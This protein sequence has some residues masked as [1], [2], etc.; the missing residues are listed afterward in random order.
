METFLFWAAVIFL[1]FVAL[2]AVFAV[3]YFLTNMFDVINGD[4]ASRS[5]MV[6]AFLFAAIYSIR[7]TVDVIE[8]L[9]FL[10]L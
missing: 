1:V 4:I 9:V 5:T 10:L 2:V 3:G 7:I 8:D 6:V